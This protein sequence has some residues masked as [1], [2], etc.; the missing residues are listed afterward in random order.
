VGGLV[1]RLGWTL[2]DLATSSNAIRL[3]QASLGRW[4]ADALPKDARIGVNDT[5][6][7]AYFSNRKTFDVCGLTTPGEARYWVAGAG[8]R[9]EHYERL[10]PTRLPTH[11]VVYTNWFAI[12]TL[13]GDFQTQRSVPGATILGGET[14]VAHVASYDL[15]G[16]GSRPQLD[17]PCEVLDE[18]DVA[19][20]ES[21][22]AH[23]Y[24]LLHAN[25]TL[26]LVVEQDGIA[27][28]GRS[29]RQTERFMMTI[30]PGGRI[31]SRVRGG[32]DVTLEISVG[33]MLGDLRRLRN[34][35]W[36]EVAWTFPRDFYSGRHRIRI[37]AREGTFTALHHWSLKPCAK[38]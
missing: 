36:Q 16:T 37:Q 22:S 2:E 27:D 3:Q 34:G 25:S 28:G 35:G 14:M 4:A 10:G 32:D 12:P 38:K 8:S 11:F 23:D 33:G 9:F 31:V 15:L 21:E 7:I 5:G 18:V 17:E 29:E 6:A 24:D 13:L 26:N 30:A 19:D 1:S 20:L